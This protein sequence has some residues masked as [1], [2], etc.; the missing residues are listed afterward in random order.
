[1][2]VRVLALWVLVTAFTA[3]AQ[4]VLRMSGEP[5]ARASKTVAPL[6]LQLQTV[7]DGHVTTYRMS[8]P[9][10]AALRRIGA[11][12]GSDEKRTTI[13]IHRDPLSESDPP[14]PG[15]RP[16]QWLAATDGGRVA[17]LL[18]ESPGASALRSAL[19]A[20]DLPE[21]TEI[22][23]ASSFAGALSNGPIAG[24]AILE[25]SR[26]HGQYWSP[27]TEG[28]AQR[29]EILIPDGADVDRVRVTLASA[30]HLVASP[31]ARFKN[32]T[33]G[34]AEPCNEDVICVAEANPAIANAASSVAKMVFTEDGVTYLCT[35]TLIRGLQRTAQVPYLYSAA[36]CVDTQSAAATLNTFWFFDAATCGE[37][38]ARAYRQLSGGAT[39]LYANAS[40]DAALLRLKESPPEGAWFAGWDLAPLPEGTA[41]VALHH[42]AGDLKKISIGQALGVTQATGGASYT[43]AGWISGST[44]G[45]SSGSGLFTLSDGEY[46]LRGALKGG[47]ASCSNSGSLANPANRDFYS[48]LDLEGANLAAWLSGGA[49]PMGDYTDLWW[50][51]DEPGWGLA[52]LQHANNH[53]V[54]V[55]LTYDRDNRAAW[56]ILP[57]RWRAT[58]VLEGTIFRTAGSPFDQPFDAALSDATPVGHGRIEFK[59]D[60]TGTAT[61]VVD[62]QTVVKPIKRQAF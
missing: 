61:F 43:T 20:R 1:M 12:G 27:V 22:R 14:L 47:S 26:R 57:G 25:A 24:N 39:L 9:G 8:A 30:S 19:V 32:G 3:S 40:T 54:A 11:S 18:V 35:A 60:G 21:G 16:L 10:A 44:E 42:P 45:G 46:V 41:I 38:F 7:A 52:V 37:Q 51:P 34:V 31:A 48:R 17:Q 53:V 49:A 23:F 50:N 6:R 29:I 59:A 36:H 15:A 58:N 56:L 5:M 33:S 28:D 4:P 13:G 62:G 2:R 55:W